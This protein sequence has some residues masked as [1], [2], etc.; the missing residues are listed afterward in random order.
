MNE[1]VLKA[2]RS[3]KVPYASSASCRM[4]NASRP[5]L[6]FTATKVS[7]KSGYDIESIEN[8]PVLAYDRFLTWGDVNP[9]QVFYD[10][11]TDCSA[12]T[13]SIRLIMTIGCYIRA[14]DRQG[15]V[16]LIVLPSDDAKRYEKVSEIVRLLELLLTI[17]NGRPLDPGFPLATEDE[18]YKSIQLLIN[19]DQYEDTIDKICIMS[20][21]NESR[22]LNNLHILQEVAYPWLSKPN[23]PVE[24]LAQI[25][26]ALKCILPLPAVDLSPELQR[27]L[28]QWLATF[29]HLQQ[30]KNVTAAIQLYKDSLQNVTHV[31]A[32]QNFTADAEDGELVNVPLMPGIRSRY[33]LFTIR[34]NDD[35]IAIPV[36][37]VENLAA[38]RTILHLFQRNEYTIKSSVRPDEFFLFANAVDG[39]NIEITE[40]NCAGLE[41]LC[42]E[43][44]FAGLDKAFQEFYK[45]KEKDA[46]IGLE[47]EEDIWDEDQGNGDTTGVGVEAIDSS[48]FRVMDIVKERARL[49]RAA[50]V[51]KKAR[52]IYAS[53]LIHGYGG[54]Q[55]VPKG[56]E[57]MKEAAES[58]DMSAWCW[59][60]RAQVLG[61]LI[62]RNDFAGF[63]CLKKAAAY[64]HKEAHFWLG[65]CYEFGIGVQADM[66]QAIDCYK[67]G[68][69]L[70]DRDCAFKYG[71]ALIWGLEVE[72]NL[73][74]ALNYL[75]NAPP[76]ANSYRKICAGLLNGEIGHSEDV[77]Q[78]KM[79]ADMGNV[80][81]QCQY[82]I[83][84]LY[85]KRMSVNLDD[86]GHY[87]KLA[88][89]NGD[90]KAQ[91]K[92]SHWLFWMNRLPESD[93][94]CSKAA[95][96]GYE[97]A[98]TDKI[99]RYR[100]EG[101]D[102]ELTV[103]WLE[104]Y[105]Q[106]GNSEAMFLYAKALNDG[107]GVP[108]DINKAI[109][110][111]EMAAD[112][113]NA[114][115]MLDYAEI[116]LFYGYGHEDSVKKAI[117]YY[118]MATDHGLVT[119]YIGYYHLIARYST[120]PSEQEEGLNYLKYAADTGHRSAQLAYALHLL[121]NSKNAESEREAA[122]YL[123]KVAETG[124]VVGIYFYGA[125][126]ER[127]RG[128]EKNLEEA[129]RCYKEAADKGYTRGLYATSVCYHHGIGCEPDLSK[130]V[131]YMKRAADCGSPYCQTTYGWM[132]RVGLDGTRRLQEA[133]SYFKAAADRGYAGGANFYGRALQNGEGVEQ[134]LEEAARYFKMAADDGFADAQVNYALCLRDGRGVHQNVKEAVRYF[135]MAAK[136]G[137]TEGQTQFGHCLRHGHGIKQDI[138]RAA[139][140]FKLAADSGSASAQFQYALLADHGEIPENLPEA[141]AYYKLAADHG[142]TKAQYNYAFFLM[143]GRGI[144]KNEAEA[145]RYYQMAANRGYPNAQFKYADCLERG[146]GCSVDLEKAASF[147]KLAAMQGYGKAE[148]RY[149]QCLENGRGVE[150]NFEEAL[151]FYVRAMDHKERAAIRAHK[152]LSR[153]MNLVGK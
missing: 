73:E 23:C 67:K 47:E 105:A 51:E 57:Y 48:E 6:Q 121:R 42:V 54:P 140:Y 35:H 16:E 61:G 141:A 124:H 143:E 29:D 70:V 94:Y 58:G 148:F 127:G 81:A 132:C 88:A 129:F 96:A 83:C 9:G 59:L 137:N 139:S 36:K 25:I 135:E 87:L 95:D 50:L 39:N 71:M 76:L 77:W 149:G 20:L 125:C 113:G 38:M 145:V 102:P 131:E 69:L 142:I 101:I 79:A 100:Y 21:L 90:L 104:Y 119:A 117:R 65:R 49:E 33:A 85:G 122:R 97:N 31:N 34:C 118:K 24:K 18:I 116:C 3:E 151:E 103:K 56:L 86:A 123:Q 55:D 68:A 19:D 153:R 93:E 10:D 4:A 41:S 106:A 78:L 84:A 111:F 17:D 98:Q 44:G 128:V 110:T 150:Q 115:A 152:E 28:S 46:T 15:Q 63:Q 45:K 32:E 1:F 13:N 144:P 107:L 52:R 8:A 133:A 75:S 91:L 12:V 130:A 40:E 11:I 134:N 62:P 136:A 7:V 120:S 112:C 30:T 80:S 146:I 82:G 26:N 27:N 2:N 74:E 22:A 14:Q 89:D 60:G 72:K 109:Q 37:T 53:F 126:L 108:Q 99:R 92:Y 43:L 138:P 64:S 114:S 147:F 5:L 66:K